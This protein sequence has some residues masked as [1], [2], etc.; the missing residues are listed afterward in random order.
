MPILSLQPFLQ[1]VAAPL[2]APPKPAG[3]PS[4]SGRQAVATA[5]LEQ[6]ASKSYHLAQAGYVVGA[7][8]KLRKEIDGECLLWR[9]FS[10]DDLNGAVLTCTGCWQS[11]DRFMSLEI[12][13]KDWCI[14]SQKPQHE[15]TFY[16]YLLENQDSWNVECV[17][18]QINLCLNRLSGLA[19]YEETHKGLRIFANPWCV[20][21]TRDFAKDK[22]MLPPASMNIKS[23][24]ENEELPDKHVDV[25]VT[26]QL[27]S[28]RVKFS[29]GPHLSIKDQ[30]DKSF[31]SPFW[32]V[33]PVADERKANMKVQNAVFEITA[34]GSTQGHHGNIND[35]LHV[36]IPIL[37][38][39]V[40]CCT[41]DL[42]T[43]FSAA[44][45]AKPVSVRGPEK[46]SKRSR[47]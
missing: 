16:P 6:L 18:S 10:I 30:N 39:K 25:G 8:V 13:K 33:Q 15:V 28:K 34:H 24:G 46:N 42:L 19:F 37:V 41:S 14:T 36:Q 7:T 44:E 47:Q 45:A 12:L 2:P 9:I 22:L 43:V 23:R 26:L 5:T 40:Q 29:I 4:G 17:K 1:V 11:Q 3:A 21:V 27:Q 38:N 31:L 32:C 20:M 35:T